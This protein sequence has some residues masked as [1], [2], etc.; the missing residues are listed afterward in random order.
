M[1][2]LHQ[3]DLVGHVLEQEPWEVLSFPAIAEQDEAFLIDSPI[4]RRWFKRKLGDALHP[5]R[6]TLQTLAGIR[7]RMGDYNF[8]SQYQQS[9]I[10]LGAP[11]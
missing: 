6:E 4:G 7:E 1:Q 5:E 10:P 8:S 11:W 9:P 3:E 2:R